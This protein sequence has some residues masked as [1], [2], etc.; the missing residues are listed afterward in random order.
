MPELKVFLSHFCISQLKLCCFPS[1]T[2]I[3]PHFGA[4]NFIALY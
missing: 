2:N 1:E 3:F 4:P